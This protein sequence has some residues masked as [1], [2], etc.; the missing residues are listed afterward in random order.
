MEQFDILELCFLP[1]TVNR[2]N[3]QKGSLGNSVL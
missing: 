1:L 2:V 3:S